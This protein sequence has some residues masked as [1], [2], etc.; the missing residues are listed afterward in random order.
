MIKPKE[1]EEELKTLIVKTIYDNTRY[2]TAA[3]NRIA[4][5]LAVVLLKDFKIEAKK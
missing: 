4:R 2:S 1:N 5:L 3:C